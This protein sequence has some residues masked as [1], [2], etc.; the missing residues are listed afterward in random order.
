MPA[1]VCPTRPSPKV[2]FSHLRVRPGSPDR[3]PI[4]QPKCFTVTAFF[5]RF[6]P[7]TNFTRIE[8][9]QKR[10]IGNLPDT[11]PG[12]FVVTDACTALYKTSF[13]Q[14][15]NAPQP[16]CARSKASESTGSHKT[17][18]VWAEKKMKHIR[19]WDLHTVGD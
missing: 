14:S 18:I 19:P 12:Q 4:C 1:K 5:W 13:G 8:G 3:S 6:V 9:F 11:K 10:A 7:D 17:R 2:P 16:E 15:D